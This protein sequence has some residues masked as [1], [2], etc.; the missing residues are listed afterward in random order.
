[1]L[2]PTVKSLDVFTTP[3]PLVFIF[4]SIS[5]SPPVAEIVGPSVVAALAI[6]ISFTAL[7]V[8]DPIINS[9]P[10]ESRMFPLRSLTIVELN[11]LIPAI[12]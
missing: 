1:M 4:R 7:S 8:A 3:V 9:F 6:V 5:A 11:V 2:P 10:V 12:F